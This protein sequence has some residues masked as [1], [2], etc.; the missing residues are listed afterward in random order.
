M[1]AV[2]RGETP[3]PPAQ[4]AV[5][6]AG[7]DEASLAWVRFHEAA[8]HLAHGD[9]RPALAAGMAGVELSFAVTGVWDDL[10][11]LWGPAADL[12]V[13]LG[14]DAAVARLIELTD[15]G[16]PRLPRG[17]QGHRELLRA[18][19]AARD[20][21]SRR[22]SQPSAARW[23]TTGPG[24]RPRRSPT[25]RPTW[26]GGWRRRAATT[27]PPRTWPPRDRR[28]SGWGRSTWLADLDPAAHPS[29]TA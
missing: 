27:R 17:L 24:G 28:T 23:S 7:D 29:T 8:V 3:E 21:L 6:R 22:P 19:L 12:A 26:A 25:P 16:R 15:D 2:A 9:L 4:S 5:E 14:D 11:H 18:R 10:T 13:R 20:G 1:L